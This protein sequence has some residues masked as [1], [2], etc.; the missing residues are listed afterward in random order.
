MA[1]KTLDVTSNEDLKKK[2]GDVEIVG[3]DI[4]KLISKASSKKEKWMKS[5][6]AMQVV[7]GIVL[8]VTTQ[9]DSNV[10]EALVFVPNAKITEKDGIYTIA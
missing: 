1:K 6:K 3:K 7:G 8:Q 10:A 2:V 5:T 9:N 4:W